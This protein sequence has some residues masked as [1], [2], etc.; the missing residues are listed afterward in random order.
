RPSEY[1]AE[2]PADFDIPHLPSSCY[3]AMDD[4]C[5]LATDVYVPVAKAGIVAPETF[6]TI[7][8]Y[9][10]YYRRFELADQTIATERSPNSVRYRKAF[11]PYGYV[12][13]VVD[14]RGTGASFGRRDAFRSP[15][16]REDYRAI[17]DWIVAQP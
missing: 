5:R 7:V 17:A 15:R 1:L 4:G 3:V 12:L 6:P 14:V 10:P 11:V 16:E 9:T 2:R 8:V 13:V